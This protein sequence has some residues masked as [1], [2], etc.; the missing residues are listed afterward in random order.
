M[1]FFRNCPPDNLTV[2]GPLKSAFFLSLFVLA[3]A[4]CSSA[5]DLGAWRR[6]AETA[7]PTNSR[8]DLASDLEK[9]EEMRQRLRLEESRHLALSLAA[10]NPENPA[11]LYRASRAESDAVLLYPKDESEN[12]G[13]AALSALDYGRRAVD[14]ADPSVAAMAQYAWAMGTSTHLQPMFERS[15]HATRTLEAIDTTLEKNSGNV[16]ALATK[17]IL[18]FRLATLPWIA[19]VMASGAPEGSVEEAIEL[20]RRCVDSVPSIENYLILARALIED[21]SAEDA[22]SLLRSAIAGPDTYPRDA[23]LR[24]DAER[25][26]RSLRQK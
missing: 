20:G 2:S 11:V 19:R 14:V 9:V 4:G 6:A 10:E 7:R 22:R 23:L 15:E 24:P 12:R 16:T 8:G 18:R 5:P 17:S 21:E 13:L 3:L 26:L 1:V 25:L